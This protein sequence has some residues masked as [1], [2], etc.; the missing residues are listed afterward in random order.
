MTVYLD[1]GYSDIEKFW[2]MSIPEVMLLLESAKRRIERQQKEH[3]AITKQQIIM[4]RNLALQTTEGIASLFDKNKRHLTGLEEYYPGLF[5][6]ETGSG[7][8]GK[9]KEMD[10]ETYAKMFM[11]WAYQRNAERHKYNK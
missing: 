5:G 10:S 9:E 4:L 11:M 6:D 1:A 7:S 2:S 8:N 3:E